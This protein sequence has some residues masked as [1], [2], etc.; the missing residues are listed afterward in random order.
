[1]LDAGPPTQVSPP[2]PGGGRPVE[3]FLGGRKRE[4]QR[5]AGTGAG[6]EEL[7]SRSWVL[8]GA[9]TEVS[10]MKGFLMGSVSSTTFKGCK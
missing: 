1:M 3:N 2:E 6:Q 5:K 7:G 4:G 9:E 8:R 10:G